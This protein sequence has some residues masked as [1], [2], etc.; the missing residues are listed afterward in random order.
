MLDIR[1]FLF[2]KLSDEKI[3]SVHDLF[4]L[5]TELTNESIQNTVFYGFNIEETE[6]IVSDEYDGNK[7][8]KRRRDGSVLQISQN[9][10]FMNKVF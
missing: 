10:Y 6:K 1:M 2:E 8:F 3:Y 4:V 7:P 5:L 9:T